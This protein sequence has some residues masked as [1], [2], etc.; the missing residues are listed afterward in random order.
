[1][2]LEQLHQIIEIEKQQSISKAAK[3]LYMGQPTLSGSLNNLEDEIGVRLFERTTGGVVP[4]PE[5]KDILQLAKQILDCSTQIM[6]YGK[7]HRELYGEVKLMITQA[8]GF[9]FSDI[10]MEFK[11][12]YPKAELNLEI[13]TPEVIVQE[14]SRG[15]AG[16]GLTMWGFL[17]E[18]TEEMLKDIGLQYQTYGT[19]SMMLYVSQDNRFAESEDVALQELQQEKFVAYS[20]SYWASVNK[21]IQATSEPLV[22][23]DREALKRMVS[24]GQVVAMLPDT[25]ALHDLYCEQGLINLI[26][27]KGSENFGQGVDHLLY[28]AKRQLTVLEKKTLELL[29]EIL[30]DLMG[31]PSYMQNGVCQKHY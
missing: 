18:Q 30:T 4:T 20:S 21:Q 28:P 13:S 17:P 10:M 5:G 8:Y 9:L 26:P 15:T 3:A 6:N 7:Q 16:I 19:H 27:I 24:T 14:V 31:E 22:M 1:M 2:R 23:T 29:H 12:R 25:F 11:K